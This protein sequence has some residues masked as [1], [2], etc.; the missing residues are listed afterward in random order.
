M[1][2]LVVITFRNQSIDEAVHNA[3]IALSK[4]AEVAIY[5]DEND[6]AQEVRNAHQLRLENPEKTFRDA[7]GRRI[8]DPKV[9]ADILRDTSNTASQERPP[10]GSATDKA[11]EET[12]TTGEF[13]RINWC[14]KCFPDVAGVFGICGYHSEQEISTLA[15]SAQAEFEKNVK[16]FEDSCS[17]PVPT[18]L[19]CRKCNPNQAGLVAICPR[20]L[21]QARS[22]LVGDNK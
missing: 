19:I 8:V 14:R 13:E 17:R 11:S 10:C 20:H 12:P 15:K 1:G 21:E 3:E 6:V 22:G 2:A 4:G 9:A 18:V 16:A 7:H 5:P